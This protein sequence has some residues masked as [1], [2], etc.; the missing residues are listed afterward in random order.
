MRSPGRLTHAWPCD[1]ACL[2]V[3]PRRPAA[4]LDAGLRRGFLLLPIGAQ[5]ALAVSP[6]REL[7]WS[8]AAD[9]QMG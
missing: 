8:T 7:A 6:K 4:W 3:G 9:P 2:P 5:R 1:L